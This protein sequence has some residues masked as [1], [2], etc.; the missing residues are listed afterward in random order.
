MTENTLERDTMHV[1]VIGADRTRERS[2]P[3]R[4]RTAASVA[5]TPAFAH[6]GQAEKAVQA[7]VR[8]RVCVRA[9]QASAQ[10]GDTRSAA[11]HARTAQTEAEMIA[12]LRDSI[13]AGTRDHRLAANA[14]QRA[15]AA[16]ADATRWATNAKKGT[17]R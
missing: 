7:A 1:G 16:A 5:G 4:R 3:Y 11:Q 17:T 10:R 12:M 14:H 13:P 2:Q 9:A 6:S 15:L 8:A